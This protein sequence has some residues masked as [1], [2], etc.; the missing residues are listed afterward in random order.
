MPSPIIQS[1]FPDIV[2]PS[3]VVLF[4]YIRGP[5]VYYL[6]LMDLFTTAFSVLPAQS[7]ALHGFPAILS[8]LS[9]GEIIC[10]ELLKPF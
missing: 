6:V 7:G 1:V 3:N 4:F 10:F 8:D 9:P 2:R 5:V